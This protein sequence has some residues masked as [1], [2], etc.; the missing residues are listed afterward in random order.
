MIPLALIRQILAGRPPQLL[1]AAG[2]KQA[3]VALILRGGD[4]ELELL[5]IRRAEHANDPWSGDLAFPGGKVDGG[6]GGPRQAAERETRE[7]LALDL[8]PAEYLG[9]LD[10][11][12]GDFL[13]VLISAFVYH[14]P[15]PQPIQCNHEVHQVH[16]LPLSRVADRRHWREATFSYRGQERAHPV[17]DLLGPGHPL[18]WG[19]TYRLLTQ[20]L[21]RLPPVA[22]HSCR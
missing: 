10:D 6:D 18:L 15:Q 22:T 14:L 8:A 9:R 7:E 13:P 2:R 21:H 17:I 4:H 19:I 20:F 5:F 3:A 12:L 1:P 16:W 11:I